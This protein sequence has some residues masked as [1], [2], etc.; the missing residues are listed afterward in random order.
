MTLSVQSSVYNGKLSDQ[1]RQMIMQA[2]RSMEGKQIEIVV[3]EKKKKR[4]LSQNA[5]YWG[6][7]IPAI[8]NMFRDYGNN[9][10]NEQV[11]EFLKSEVGKM[12]QT[13]MLPDGEVKEICGSSA[14][15]KT[16]EFE[17]YLTKVRAWAAEWGVIIP[18]PNE[19]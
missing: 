5:F 3:K 19:E 1:A 9:V 7:V 18:M 11:H 8:T 13:I 2:L 15:L 10:D 14:A 16:M 6:C 17:N 12:N 4:S